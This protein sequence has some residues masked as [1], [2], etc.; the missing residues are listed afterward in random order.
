[1]RAI[2]GVRI[3][4]RLKA[5]LHV[6]KEGRVEVA[7]KRLG[8]KNAMEYLCQKALD[9]PPDE[10]YPFYVM[11]THHPKNGLLL[12]EYLREQGHFHINSNPHKYHRRKAK[13]QKV[14]HLIGWALFFAV[15]FRHL[16]GGKV[17]AKQKW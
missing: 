2:R 4:V 9:R 5:I 3:V 10:A 15:H 14:F 13:N 11:Y 8:F 7:A 12:A 16:N 17:L 1:M 6:T